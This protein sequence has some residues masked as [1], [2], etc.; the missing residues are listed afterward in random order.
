MPDKCPGACADIEKPWII[1]S[2][3]TVDGHR[4]YMN[5]IRLSQKKDV[6]CYCSGTTKEKIKQLIDD[7]INDLD[8]I[9][10]KTGACSG[11][12]ACDTLILEL[13]AEYR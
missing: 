2:I 5:D 1:R 11:C 8:S 7:G 6:I 13:M 9:S 3:R 12:G 4:R 10:R